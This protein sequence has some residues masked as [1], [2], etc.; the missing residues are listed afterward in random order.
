[1]TTILILIVMGLSEMGGATVDI[2]TVE[3]RAPDACEVALNAAS[4]QSRQNFR[5]TGVCVPKDTR[6]F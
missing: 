5:I 2:E 6:G 3:F 1:M 4:A